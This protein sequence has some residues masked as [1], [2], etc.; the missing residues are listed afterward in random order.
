MA[1]RPHRPKVERLGRR[2]SPCPRL[3]RRYN[4]LDR[5]L[6][7]L[8]PSAALVRGVWYRVLESGRRGFDEGTAARQAMLKTAAMHRNRQV[9]D[10][11]L[12][13]Q[14]TPP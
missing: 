7:R 3:D 13:K 11:T 2:T 14:L 8:P 5:L 6:A 10:A 1:W 4:G 12:R 9:A